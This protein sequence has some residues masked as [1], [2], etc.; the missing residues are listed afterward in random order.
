MHFSQIFRL[1]A[2]LTATAMV[3]LGSFSVDAQ[4][5]AQGQGASQISRSDSVKGKGSDRRSDKI[6]TFVRE[7]LDQLRAQGITRANARARGASGLSTALVHIDDQAAIQTYV[8]VDSLSD[9][10]RNRLED[11]EVRIEHANM[12]AGM[13]QAW[14]PADRIEAVADLD[15]VS[16]VVRPDYARPRAGSVL[17]EGDSILRANELR[18]RGF[19]GAGVKVGVISDGANNVGD[20]V[21]SG[22]LPSGVTIFGSCFSSGFPGDCNEGTAMLEIIHDLAPGAQLAMSETN[23]SLDFINGITTLKDTFGAHII[24]DDLGFFGEAFFADGPIAQAVAAVTSDVLF[25]T[26]GGN[27]A[28]GHY[29][30]NFVSTPGLF[31]FPVHNWSGGDRSMDLDIPPGVTVDIFLQWNDQFGSSGND[32]DLYMYESSESLVLCATCQSFAAQD[33]NDDP[34][35]FVSYTNTTGAT[36][37][38]LLQVERFSG[39][40]RRVEL[41][42]LSNAAGSVIADPYNNPAGSIF[43]HPAVQDAVTVAAIDWLDPGNDTIE[44]FSSRGPSR[45]DFPSVVSRPKPEITG[46]DGVSV[47]GAGG[48]SSTFFGTSAAAPHIA[49]IAA[50]LK[51][52]APTATPL[53]LRTALADGAV[54]LGPA[55]RDSIYGWGR[56]D[57]IGSSDTL[58]VAGPDTVALPWLP[59][60]LD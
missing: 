5:A 26:A 54:D 27:D 44:P 14:I 53:D 51:Q 48:F 22:N 55:G 41:F 43:G 35:E 32:Y 9:G 46:I 52:Q 36:V 42:I 17:T 3:A 29:E 25:V 38:A 19:N 15:F 18:A 39:A 45:I 50:Q 33:G 34:I 28:Q 24:V 11:L 58:V 23:T 16:R 20:A 8:H 12:A 1:G 56:A 47:S 59:L 57:A 6:G 2:V 4:E 10:Q 60:L 49:A 37:R 13:V 21:A 31:G 40:N 30:A 7:R